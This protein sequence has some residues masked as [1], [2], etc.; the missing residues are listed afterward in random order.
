MKGKINLYSS[1][2]ERMLE[3]RYPFSRP[4]LHAAAYFVLDNNWYAI[5]YDGTVIPIS[6]VSNEERTTIPSTSHLYRNL[7][8]VLLEMINFVGPFGSFRSNEIFQLLKT[9]GPTVQASDD[10]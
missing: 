2:N 3:A 6:S 8:P 10:L 9:Y 4:F 5:T 1:E 7:E